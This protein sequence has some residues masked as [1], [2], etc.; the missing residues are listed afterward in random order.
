MKQP[1]LFFVLFG[2]LYLACY[3]SKQ[4]ATGRQQVRNL[5][6]YAGGALL[7]LCLVV[8]WSA[9]SGS[10]DRFW[11]WTVTYVREYGTMVSWTVALS[12]FT[13]GV[14]RLV[15]GFTWRS[16]ARLR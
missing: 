13:V 9:L 10:I 7:P 4:P 3:Q 8:I 2:A 16:A 12:R 15:D 11:F 1:G 5:I 6:F 14:S